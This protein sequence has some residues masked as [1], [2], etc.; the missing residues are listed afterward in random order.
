M[1]AHHIPVA[2]TGVHGLEAAPT[3]QRLEAAVR[4]HQ[5]LGAFFGEGMELRFTL[6][7]HIDLAAP[8]T[9]GLLF[10]AQVGP[11]FV[12]NLGSCLASA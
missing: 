2:T 5:V 7:E 1:Y 6:V 10:K 12:S 9:F 3:D 4:F 8:H 11:A